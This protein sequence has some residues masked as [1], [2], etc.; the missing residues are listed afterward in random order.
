MKTDFLYLLVFLA[1]LAGCQ[2]DAGKKP[3]KETPVAPKVDLPDLPVPDF[4]AERAFQY[5]E[6]QLSFGPRVPNT[7]AHASCANWLMEEFSAHGATVTSQPALVTAHDG[8][9]LNLQNIIASFQP[10]K[11]QRIMLSAHWDSRPYADQDNERRNEPIPGAN[12]GASGVAVLL[13]IARHLG[14]AN[15]YIGVDLFLWDGEDY[16]VSEVQDSY[17]LG[18]QYWAKN[19]HIPN[20]RAMYGINLDMVG[21]KDAFFPKEGQSLRF[22]PSVVEKVWDTAARLGYDNHFSMM[23]SEGIIDDHLYLNVLAGIPYID[24]IH[25]PEGKGFFPAWHTHDDDI[26]V[27]DPATLK[28]V[29]QTVLAVVYGEE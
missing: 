6:K 16:G 7:G 1:L 29:G 27:I 9:Q 17:C 13:E 2:E 20:Y 26:G 24:I 21:A 8:K 22:A 28:A 5:I 3:V 11:K 10:E 18:S 15:P 19:K 4:S 14:Q 23:A 25:Q 12:D